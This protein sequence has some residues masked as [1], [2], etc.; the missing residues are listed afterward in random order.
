MK[1]SFLLTLCAFCLASTGCNR[2]EQPAAAFRAGTEREQGL[3]VIPAGSPQLAQIRVEPVVMGKFNLEEVVAPGKVEANPNRIAR[4]LAPI[5]GR[6]RQVW[7]TLGDAVTEGQP[8]LSIE[9]PE[10]SALLAMHA[11]LQAELTQARSALKKA[12]AD[13]SRLRDLYEHRA[14][15]LKEVLEAENEETQAQAA[16][17]QATARIEECVA[18]LALL[19]LEP[20]QRDR[21]VVVRA[22]ISG[23][24]M[25]IAVVPGEFRNDSG[26]N[27]MT[28]ADLRSVWIAAD[29]PESSI[30]LVQRGEPIQ[31]ELAAYPGEVFHGRVMR[32]ADAV[33]PGTRTVKVLAE[34]PNPTGR[35]KP[36]MFGRIRHSHG[37]QSAPAV[38]SSAILQRQGRNVVLREEAPGTFREVTVKTGPS[39]GGFTAV[40]EGLKEGDRVVVDGAVLLRTH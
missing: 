11:Q 8:L 36:E 12:S 20:G 3:I 23:K 18:R 17:A 31:C 1:R 29:V 5:A 7:V 14:V 21:E 33:D 24:V 38:R 30:R 40:Y 37:T 26:A 25:E 32:I 6:V 16:V 28:I 2:V 22:P 4:V 35:L 39:E 13:L 10:A 15:A 19:G 27:L 9:S 34:I